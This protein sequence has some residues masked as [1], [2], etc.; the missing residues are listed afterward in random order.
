[1]RLRI[2]S[3]LLVASLLATGCAASPPPPS[4]SPSVAPVTI[5]QIDAAHV[6]SVQV[7]L[8]GDLELAS[9]QI[10][11][12]AQGDTVVLS[13]TVGTADERQRAESL[14]RSVKGV[15]KIDNRIE[16]RPAQ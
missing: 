16:V 10:A 9:E 7:R 2:L 4:P 15:E 3:A 8:K 5:P 6:T 14:A 13:G 11:V 1:M 12:T